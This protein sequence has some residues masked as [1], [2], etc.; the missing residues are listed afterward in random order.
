MNSW[1]GYKVF[2]VSLKVK[3]WDC[4]NDLSNVRVQNPKNTFCNKSPPKVSFKSDQ[5]PRRTF[6]QTSTKGSDKRSLIKDFHFA[7]FPQE[8]SSFDKTAGPLGLWIIYAFTMQ[9]VRLSNALPVAIRRAQT[10]AI[11]KY[12]VKKHYLSSCR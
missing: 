9:A 6:C 11:S 5:N 1:H 7:N 2:L 8:G 3:T 4:Q 10:L 12:L